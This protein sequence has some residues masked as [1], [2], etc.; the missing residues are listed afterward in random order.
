MDTESPLRALANYQRR[1]RRGLHAAHKALAKL[2]ARRPGPTLGEKI[3]DGC[4]ATAIWL[5]CVAILYGGAFGLAW[6]ADEP[7][8]DPPGRICDEQTKQCW[9]EAGWHFEQSPRGHRIAV[10][11]LP[12]N[13][14]ARASATLTLRSYGTG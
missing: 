10:H 7:P 6:L 9:P 4:I 11:D 8:L 1:Y 3:K 5:G 2:A 13:A 12:R 14:A